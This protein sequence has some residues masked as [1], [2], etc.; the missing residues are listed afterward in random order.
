MEP[1]SDRV[2]SSATSAPKNRLDGQ[3]SSP[4]AGA[5]Y[6]FEIDLESDT[7]HARVVRLVGRDRRVLEL[8]PATGYMSRVLRDRGCSVVGIEVDPAMAKQATRYAERVIVGDLDTMD[9][10]SDLGEDR[11]DVIVAADVLEH[12]KD[13]LAALRRLRAFLA[14]D[15]FFV[16]SLPN[17]AHGSVRLALLGGHFTYQKTGLLDETHLRFFTR[18]SVDRLLDEAELGAAEIH[19]QEL[20]ID[21]SEVPFKR[22]AVSEELLHELERDPDA[23]TYQFVIKA[24]PLEVH[25]L[26]EM[27]RRMR[28][29]AHENARLRSLEP[30]VRTL[31][32]AVAAMSGRE[33][34]VRG[35]LIQAH[36]EAL[37]RDEEIDRLQRELLPLRTAMDRVRATPFGRAYGKMRRFQRLASAL[38]QRLRRL[39]ASLRR[40]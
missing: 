22:D 35:A 23:Q 12:L 4:A 26:R 28:E 33:G 40:P 37:Q 11:F 7:T 17:V 6:E 14:P 15:G 25:G 16:I 3:A 18:E 39:E 30:Q 38:V 10:D 24:I 1:E 27:Q 34:R 9:L 20:S 36:E 32:D 5:R 21:A 13:P 29:L 31:Q 8:G 2:A 19:H